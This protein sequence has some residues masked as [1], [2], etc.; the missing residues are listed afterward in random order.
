MSNVFEIG[1][2]VFFEMYFEIIGNGGGP[3]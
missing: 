2:N 1:E 3:G